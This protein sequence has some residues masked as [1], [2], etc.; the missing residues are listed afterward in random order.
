M[1]IW[2]HLK[3]KVQGELFFKY[4]WLQCRQIKDLHESDR[5]NMV[6]KEKKTEL[7]VLLLGEGTKLM[8]KF[9]KLLLK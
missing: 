6:S 9:Y 1:K 7:E 2:C 5:K 4:G 8:S 3:E